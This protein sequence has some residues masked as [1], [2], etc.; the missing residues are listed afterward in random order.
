MDAHC[1]WIN[2]CVGVSNH[3]FYLL[4]LL[5]TLISSVI[6]IGCVGDATYNILF[7]RN[8]AR[9]AWFLPDFWLYFWSIVICLAL[10]AYF[11]LQSLT[12]IAEQ[13]ES[14]SEN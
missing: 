4:F 11:G 9:R 6:V 3:K 7:V 14:F 1:P 13:I 10:G 5:Y 8:Q 2:N 12:L